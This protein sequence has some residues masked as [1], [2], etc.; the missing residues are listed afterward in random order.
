MIPIIGF[1]PDADPMTPGILTDCV[2]VIP[3]ESGYKGAP[4]AASVGV[5]ALASACAGSA[6]MSD[7]AGARRFFAGTSTKLWEYNGT[8]WVDVSR[9]TSYTLGTDDRWSFIQYANASLA[10]NVTARIQRSVTSGAFADIATAPQAAIIEAAKGFVLAFNTNEATYGVSQDRWWCSALNNETDW[11]P[12]L[13]T[14]CTTGRLIGGSGPI[15]AARRFGD[16]V[17]AY[18]GRSM[19][20][21]RF[22]DAPVVWG[23]QQ[24]SNDV[25]CIGQDAVVDTM[26]GHVFVG[27]DNL[28]L[29]DGTTPRPLDGSG[30]VRTWLFADMN[31]LYRY[32]TVLS[33]D[34]INYT[35]AMYYVSAG[36]AGVLD[37]CIVYHALRREWGRADI[38]IQAVVAYVAPAITYD[39][40]SA[41]VTTYDSGPTIPFDSPYWTA[42]SSVQ[43]I[44]NSAN[45][46]QSLSGATVASSF[47]T[48]DLGDD[49]GYS[50]L[51]NLRVRYH[52]APL[53]S[54]ATGLYKQAA[55]DS[56]TAAASSVMSDGRHNM[57]QSGRFHR[58]L[59]A[60]TGDWK[61]TAVRGEFKA[62]GQR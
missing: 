48:G 9:A 12:A 41:L 44:F 42:G 37:R 25:G 34:R 61:A 7:L 2:N 26:I 32:K 46:L 45:T 8:A 1:A 53:T 51:T 60:Q 10:S 20:V 52:V 23:W 55:G 54:T 38:G 57:R 5:P 22:Q 29:Y 43:S 56:L 50:S 28:Y 17:V 14:L 35:I 16:D 31:P 47:T 18:K 36:S 6:V 40:G 3:C 49:Q 11:T 58:A 39:G 24:V 19:F 30:L 59:V 13:S 4:S 33:W 27:S 62:G 21:G 15:T